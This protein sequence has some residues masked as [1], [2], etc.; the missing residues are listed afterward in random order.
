MSSVSLPG[1]RLGDLWRAFTVCL[2]TLQS[3]N[4]QRQYPQGCSVLR[5][6]EETDWRMSSHSGAAPAPWEPKQT[7]GDRRN[8]SDSSRTLHI[9]TQGYLKCTPCSHVPTP[10]RVCILDRKWEGGGWKWWAFFYVL[11]VLLWLCGVISN[12]YPMWFFANNSFL[13]FSLE[14]SI[15]K[16]RIMAAFL[17]QRKPWTFNCNKRITE[18]GVRGWGVGLW[19]SAED[20]RSP[21]SHWNQ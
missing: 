18:A 15:K 19:L 21:G 20:W 6:R 12:S 9:R 3:V 1:A 8:L 10:S 11:G 5:G 17:S 2:L 16:L 14:L 7:S 4:P 13:N